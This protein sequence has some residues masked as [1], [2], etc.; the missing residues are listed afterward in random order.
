MFVSKFALLPRRVAFLF[1]LSCILVSADGAE[2]VMTNESI[3]YVP[4]AIPNGP[5][6][7]LPKL[8]ELMVSGDQGATWSAYQQ[9]PPQEGRFSFQAGGDGTYFFATR[10]IDQ[11]GQSKPE[12]VTDP[13]LV[14]VVDRSQPSLKLQTNLESDGRITIGWQ[15]QDAH[16]V[17]KSLT[18]RYR[19]ADASDT[20][21]WQ[22]ADVR[23]HSFL[24]PNGDLVGHMSFWP[25][26]GSHAIQ[27]L[28]ETQ[29]RAGNMA[30]VNREV[31]TAPKLPNLT[32]QGP[33]LPLMAKGSRPTPSIGPVPAVRK[34]TGP[35]VPNQST[36]WEP[37]TVRHAPVP[38]RDMAFAPSEVRLGGQQMATQPPVAS[39]Y[40]STPH[41]RIEEGPERTKSPSARSAPP[42]H[43]SFGPSSDYRISKSRQF[44]LDY[45][46]ESGADVDV[47]RVEVWF[48]D[49]GGRSWQHM[50]DD[51][52]RV[53]P[54]LVSVP[55]DGMY[56]FR[57][58]VQSK[59]GLAARPPVNGDPADVWVRI[60]ASA[61]TT[62]LTSAQF[63]R[64]SELGTLKITWDVRDE[65]LSDHPVTLLYSGESNGPWRRIAAELPN[66]GQYDWR[67]DDRVP[68]RI[69]LRL[70]ANDRAGNVGI[71]A[72]RDPIKSEELSPRGVIRDVRPASH[73]P[74]R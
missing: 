54:Y 7:T 26:A 37:E 47:F 67:V 36:A 46:V 11:N 18:I 10:T 62:R 64:G 73:S 23:P 22:P 33:A 9:R 53:S 63:G 21:S 55:S 51:E 56:G 25:P 35:S 71:D 70:E 50:G 2:P 48:T 38:H 60:D 34:P 52:D 19:D 1:C 61:P 24:K 39:R 57:L 4:F 30:V 41:A 13:E 74:R 40:P 43:N 16:L 15:V 32:E 65:D 6:E 17:P 49:D 20:A 66:T 59:Q 42:V 31:A 14:V 58:I 27:I 28:A 72:L 3:F 68:S 8:V 69:Y 29:D 44:H 5:S 45:D 12:Q